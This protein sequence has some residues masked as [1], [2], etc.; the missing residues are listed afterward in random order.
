MIRN[1]NYRCCS[2]GVGRTAHVRPVEPHEASRAAA[3]GGSRSA[4]K[5]AGFGQVEREGVQAGHSPHLCIYLQLIGGSYSHNV[6]SSTCVCAARSSRAS[7]RRCARARTSCAACARSSS[8]RR[9][10]AR[11]SSAISRAATGSSRASRRTPT[12]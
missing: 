2:E 7:R 12:S 6:C 11:C 9:R 1:L 10:R 4:R 5:R 3:A 8:A